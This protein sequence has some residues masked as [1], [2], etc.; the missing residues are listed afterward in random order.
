MEKGF[1]RSSYGNRRMSLYLRRG[2]GR[3]RVIG[4]TGFSLVGVRGGGGGGIGR[5]NSSRTNKK[6]IFDRWIGGHVV[7]AGVALEAS[8]L[9]EATGNNVKENILLS[10]GQ[11]GG[12]P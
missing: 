9:T 11:G 5:S 2:G 1:L 4:E 6:D 10:A 8:A 3:G 12:V 7:Y